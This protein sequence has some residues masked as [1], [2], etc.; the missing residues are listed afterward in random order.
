MNHL[1][2]VSQKCECHSLWK[3]SLPVLAR[4]IYGFILVSY[5]LFHEVFVRSFSVDDSK[6]VEEQILVARSQLATEDH[7]SGRLEALHRLVLP[8]RL[9]CQFLRFLLD[10]DLHLSSLFD[11]MLPVLLLGL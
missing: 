9:Y 2:H 3:K 5:F 10:K 7:H 8:S 4:S 1:A 11:L 6:T